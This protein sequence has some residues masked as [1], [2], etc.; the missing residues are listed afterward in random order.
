MSFRSSAWKFGLGS[1]IGVAVL[2]IVYTTVLA[3][4]LATLPSANEPIRG[5]AFVTLEVL[6]LLLAPLTVCL[7]AA[8]HLWAP[9][10]RRA[11]SLAA[12][13]FMA[14]VAGLTGTL[15][16]TILSL[17]GHSTI[18]VSSWFRHLFSFEW[19]SIAYAVDIAAWDIFFPLSMLS[20]APVFRGSRL[21]NII[22]A[23]AVLSGGLSLAG[24]LGPLTG[25][26]RLRNIGIVGYAVVFPVMAAAVALLFHRTY[27]SQSTNS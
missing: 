1:S 12:A 13:L 19:P 7:M 18:V 15:H 26:M 27:V 10:D 8:I 5:P 21:G 20:V 6:I 16:L 3:I 22:S 24:L 11:L 9:P 23:L 4:A 14:I 25:D 2:S 17:S